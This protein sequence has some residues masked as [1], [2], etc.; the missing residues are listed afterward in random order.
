MKSVN[1]YPKYRG[2]ACSPEGEFEVVE[3]GAEFVLVVE[4]EDP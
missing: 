4:G 2:K 3:L 1:M